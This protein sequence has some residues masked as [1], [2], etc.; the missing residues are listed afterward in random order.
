MWGL[1][2]AY[3]SRPAHDF[4]RAF[5]LPACQCCHHSEAVDVLAQRGKTAITMRRFSITL[6]IASG[7]LL[8]ACARSRAFA[9][10]LPQRKSAL[11][12]DARWPE[13]PCACRR[14]QPWRPSRTRPT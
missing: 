11:L 10:D 7:L 12:R 13:P 5:P 2:S 14:P 6:V 9:A 1:V 4:S 3:L 8:V